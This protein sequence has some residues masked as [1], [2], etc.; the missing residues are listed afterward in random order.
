MSDERIVSFIN[1]LDKGNT[2]FLNEIERKAIEDGVPIIRRQTQSFL[3]T[4]LMEKKPANILEVGAAVGFSSLLMAEY[5][6][7]YTKITTIEKVE[8]RIKDCRENYKKTELSKKI[9]LIEG[10]ATLVLKELSGEFDFVFMDAAKAQYINFMPDVMR[11]LRSGGILISDNV[12]QDGDV[13]ESKFA[14]CRRDRTIHKRMREYL[15]SLCNSKELVTTILPIG[16]GVAF[17]V[18]K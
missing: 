11:L 2:P 3:K 16:D 4:L 1:S 17:S 10:D 14:V 8:K 9:N 15:Y 18:K 5:T 7:E 13:I 6:P 12:L